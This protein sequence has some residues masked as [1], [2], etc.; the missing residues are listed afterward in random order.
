MGGA[1]VGCGVYAVV[2]REGNQIWPF[3]YGGKRGYE[4]AEEA[5]AGL[6]RY[7]NDVE[8]IEVKGG[9]REDRF[10]NTKAEDWEEIWE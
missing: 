6:R 2:D 1:D 3:R 4:D 7:R 5:A 8:V 9:R 10:D